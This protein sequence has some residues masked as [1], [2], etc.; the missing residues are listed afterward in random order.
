MQ[1]RQ[2]LFSPTCTIPV[3]QKTPRL[4][5]RQGRE[6]ISR[7][8]TLID[9]FLRPALLL[10]WVLLAKTAFLP[11]LRS[12][13]KQPWLPVHTNHRLSAAKIK[14]ML[15]L[16]AFYLKLLNTLSKSPLKVNMIESFSCFLLIFTFPVQGDNFGLT[17]RFFYFHENIFSQSSYCSNAGH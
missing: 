13:H 12:A 5:Q 6:V 9:R 11:Q 15:S 4:W 14:P 1:R 2:R 10:V 16:T 7:G 8:S 3:N 17:I